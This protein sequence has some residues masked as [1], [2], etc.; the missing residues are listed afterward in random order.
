MELNHLVLIQKDILKLQF[1]N[2]ET[3]TSNQF[4][5][6]VLRK[7]GW[8]IDTPNEKRISMNHLLE[9]LTE[10]NQA[11]YNSSRKSNGFHF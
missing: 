9:Y 6:T 8:Y 4:I 10:L 7:T 2:H 11:L 3:E 5:E 1:N